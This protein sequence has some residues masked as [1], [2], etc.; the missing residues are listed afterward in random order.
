MM[1]YIFFFQVLSGVSVIPAAGVT[2]WLL[3]DKMRILSPLNSLS[4][5][6]EATLPMEEVD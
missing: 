3:E 6:S 1:L 2:V 4:K 5:Q